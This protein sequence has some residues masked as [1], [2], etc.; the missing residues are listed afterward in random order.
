M[1][2]TV[3]SVAVV[4]MLAACGGSKVS[5]PQVERADT[6]TADSSQQME[7]SD[8]EP[9][10]AADGLFDDFVY[11]YMA[12]RAFQLERTDF[13]LPNRVDGKNHPIARKDWKHDWLYKNQDVYTMI[14]DGEQSLHA[15][16][17]TAV[18]QVTVEWVYLD[19]K[20]VKQYLFK[21]RQGQWHLTGL[22]SHSLR[23]N[24]NSD[25]YH[26]YRQFSSDPAY[27]LKHI[28]NPFRFKTYDYDNFQNLEG[29]LDVNQW[30]DFK[31]VLPQRVITNINYG[32]SYANSPQR[33]LMICSLSGGMGCS[34]TFT[35]KK[36]TWMLESLE[37]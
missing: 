17:D 37:N 12:N 3:C 6:V 10:Y 15:E 30:Q 22:D 9:P 28:E 33:V 25:F 18:K 31:P 13:P 1:K 21:K 34:L 35:H 8:S 23:R 11:S 4:L 20:R 19:Q 26:F 16:K 7:A 29:L 2:K 14:L 24:E 32:Q 36:G 5:D 27:Q